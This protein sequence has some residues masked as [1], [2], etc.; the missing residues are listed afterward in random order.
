MPNPFSN[1]NTNSNGAIRVTDAGTG[2]SKVEYSWYKCEIKKITVSTKWIVPYKDVPETVETVV[3]DK[4]VSTKEKTIFL[5]TSSKGK[6]ITIKVTREGGKCKTSGHKEYEMTHPSCEGEDKGTKTE[7]ISYDTNKI[8]TTNQY[9][10][11][12]GEFHT[13]HCKVTPV[14]ENRLIPN[15]STV[16]IKYFKIKEANVFKIDNDYAVFKYIDLPIPLVGDKEFVTK[17]SHATCKGKIEYQIV[18]YPDVSFELKVSFGSEIDKKNTK[19]DDSRYEIGHTQAEIKT[20]NIVNTVTKDVKALTKGAFV[21]HDPTKFRVLLPSINFSAYFDGG[22]N[23]GEGYNGEKYEVRLTPD[24]FLQAWSQFGKIKKLKGLERIIKMKYDKDK[25]GWGLLK[26]L[27]CIDNEDKKKF[28]KYKPYRINL[29]PPNVLLSGKW[30]Y[31][32]SK[33]LTKPG[34]FIDISLVFNPLICV[35]LTVD[36]LYLLLGLLPCV[37]PGLYVILKNLNTIF[38]TVI[39]HGYEEKY[40]GCEPF[41][42]NVD[43]YIN[44]VITGSIS[45]NV[46]WIINTTE[47]I[48]SN[49]TRTAVE[50]VL[51]CDLMAGVKASINIFYFVSAECELSASGSTGI[52]FLLEF[53]NRILQEEGIEA[54]YK[55]IFLG[56]EFKLCA[57]VQVGLM[58]S[59]SL[60]DSYE[61]QG[62]AF[63][64]EKAELCS[65]KLW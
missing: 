15:E 33:D 26:Y 29:N 55:I 40:T 41:D 24:E 9:M 1:P 28:N 20:N 58:K 49:S 60:G 7:Y 6:D 50:G 32:T 19:G 3:F 42:V 48:N 18:S 27:F 46:H 16:K 53:E 62:F 37:G 57:K 2:G 11:V 47:S 38:E 21:Y 25:G 65:G 52:K 4:N 14:K 64:I 45:G 56:L 59:I 43:V 30:Q 35:S 31:H 61:E 39:G 8:I 36:V 10:T 5:I 51:K 63:G 12:P 13:N 23:K 44:F 54:F 22:T 17:F 34:R